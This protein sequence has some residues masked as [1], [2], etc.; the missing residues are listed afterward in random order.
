MK[1]NEH[2]VWTGGK[3]L[4]NWSGLVGVLPHETPQQMC[5]AKDDTGFNTR[6]AGL[7]TT[8]DRKGDLNK[9]QRRLKE[10]LET[11]GLDSISYLKDPEDQAKMVNVISYHTRFSFDY[12]KKSAV[13]QKIVYDQYDLANDTSAQMTFLHT[14]DETLCDEVDDRIESTFTFRK[15]RWR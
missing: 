2:A 8:F 7:E 13:T 12:A 9:L 10:A 14:L 11:R 5:F 15:S 3:P 4:A 1:E 6:C